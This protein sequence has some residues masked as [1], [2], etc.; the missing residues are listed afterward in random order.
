MK[1]VLTSLLMNK[2]KFR[3]QVLLKNKSQFCKSQLKQTSS[4]LHGIACRLFFFLLCSDYKQLLDE[5]FVVSRIIKVEIGVIY[6]PKPTTEADWNY[7][8]N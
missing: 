8:N 5:V 4:F 1:I 2:L 3:F 6:Q 7:N